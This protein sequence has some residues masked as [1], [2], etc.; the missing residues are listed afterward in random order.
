MVRQARDRGYAAQFI[1][2]DSLTNEEFGM[3]T[4]PAGDGTLLTFQ[5]DPR[6]N[7]G[8]EAVVGRFRDRDFEPAGY[9]LHT[10][11]AVQVWAQAAEQAGSL[12]LDAVVASLRRGQFETV[13]GNIGF[14]HK[15]DVTA[16][17]YIW[18]VWKNGIYVPV[19]EQ[20]Q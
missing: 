14:D 16:P 13:L 9:T 12:A 6:S 5:P 8:A 18:Y 20:Q 11:A 17:G 7:T 3:I 4:G 2:G 10:Y 1:G 15:G 19:S